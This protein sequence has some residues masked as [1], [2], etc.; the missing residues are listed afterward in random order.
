MTRKLMSSPIASVL[1]WIG[2]RFG[3][4]EQLRASEERFRALV[5]SAPD[6]MLVVDGEGTMVVVNRQTERLFGVFTRGATRPTRLKPRSCRRKPG[7]RTSVIARPFPSM[8]APGKW[9]GTSK[10]LRKDGSEFTVEIS[11]SPIQTGAGLNIACAI[12]DVSVRKRSENAWRQSEAMLRQIADA[13]PQIVWSAKPDGN[14]DYYNQRWYEYTGFD[15][16]QSKDWGWRPVMHPDD[17]SNVEE[18][19]RQAYTGGGS[20]EVEVRLRRVSDGIYRWHLARA[21]P[22]R[23]GAGCIE[24]WMGTSTDIDDFKRADAEIQ[25]LNETLARNVQQRTVQL[26]ASENRF[27]WLVESVQDYAI[28]ILDPDGRV[29]S[30]TAAAERIEGY[31]EKEIV[32]QHFS[33]FYTPEDIAA[34]MPERHLRIAAAQGQSAEE[35]WRGTKRRLKILR[36]RSDHGVT[37]RSGQASR[38]FEH[39]SRHYRTPTGGA[40]TGADQ[41]ARRGGQSSQERFS[42]GDQP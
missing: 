7:R 10:A 23:D 16:E 41:A 24:R 20:F 4:E 28:L 25:S 11:L 21:V 33:R 9:V 12:R 32:G 42:G 29:A 30:W 36:K 6:A 3:M 37:R 5:E 14:L 35:G 26:Q 22:I 39:Y 8:P 27:Q 18:R 1:A 2:R 38:L 31:T 15:F 40:G 17:V 34:G 19:W 13:M